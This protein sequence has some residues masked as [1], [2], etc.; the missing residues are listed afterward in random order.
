MWGVRRRDAARHKESGWLIRPDS[1][2]GGALLLSPVLFI[3]ICY[4]LLALPTVSRL[5]VQ[6][7][8]F[9]SLSWPT[10]ASTG[11]FLGWRLL[12]VR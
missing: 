12:C 6:L 3:S 1:E 11:A 10:R 5:G 8:A 7:R 4:L 2:T 9:L